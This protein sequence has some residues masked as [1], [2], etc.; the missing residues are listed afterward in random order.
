MGDK[1]VTKILDIKPLKHNT[2]KNVIH[3]DGDF[4]GFCYC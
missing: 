3:C 1:N 4:D 2:K